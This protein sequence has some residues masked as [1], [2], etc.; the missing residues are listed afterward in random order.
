MHADETTGRAAAALSYV[1]VACTEYLTFDARRRPLRRRHRR[2]RE[3][4]VPQELHHL[5]PD[6]QLGEI[7]V[8]IDPIQ[9]V[10]AELHVPIEY[11][12]DRDWIDPNQT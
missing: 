11:V 12:V 4:A 2:H 6:L 10:D 1:H 3:P 5:P 9:A 7:A 8:Q